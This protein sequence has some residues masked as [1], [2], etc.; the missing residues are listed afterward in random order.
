MWHTVKFTLSGI[1]KLACFALALYVVPTFVIFAVQAPMTALADIANQTTL[2]L[3]ELA[4]YVAGGWL[5]L[6][7]TTYF[8]WRT[9]RTF[10][11]L[12][13]LPALL[14]VLPAAVLVGSAF[15]AM[16]GAG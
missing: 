5:A 3:L 12:S 1:V 11:D 10:R 7:W 15:V 6:V 8:G 13:C 9:I 4:A 16:A 14:M 2:Q